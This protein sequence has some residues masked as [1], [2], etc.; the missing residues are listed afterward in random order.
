MASYNSI[1][2][3]NGNENQNI[4]EYFK[5]AGSNPSSN[6]YKLAQ[7]YYTA[8]GRESYGMYRVTNKLEDIQEYLL[9]QG[10]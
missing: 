9:N 1:V 2:N 8:L 4:N 10:H 7:I 3:P 6:L 5:N